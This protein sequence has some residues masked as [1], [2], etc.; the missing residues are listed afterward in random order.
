MPIALREAEILWDG[1]LAGG[2]GTLS[3][4]SGAL[5]QLDV[6]WASRTERPDGKTSPEELIAAAHASCFAM[7]LALVLGE[8]HTPPKR[9][10]VNAAC[11]LDEVDSAPRITTIELTV[12]AHVPGLEQAGFEQQVGRAGD[13]CPV[14]N[15]LRGNVEISVRSELEQ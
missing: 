11:T 1:P 13:L 4:G 3:S 2:T 15:A 12:R 5:G 7:A 9:L 8:N 10:T 14:S 6:T